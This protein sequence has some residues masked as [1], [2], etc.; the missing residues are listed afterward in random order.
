MNHFNG[1]E[2]DDE[3]F[4]EKCGDVLCAAFMQAEKD[5]D[6]DRN[7]I[8][9]EMDWLE[10]QWRLAESFQQRSE[11][12]SRSSAH[13]V[14]ENWARTALFRTHESQ[15]LSSIV[16]GDCSQFYSKKNLDYWFFHDRKDYYLHIQWLNTLV[17]SI[18]NGNFIVSA[19]TYNTVSDRVYKIS[20]RLWSRIARHALWAESA[21]QHDLSRHQWL[22]SWFTYAFSYQTIYYI[23]EQIEYHEPT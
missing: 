20:S 3:L 5:K 4:L 16:N 1:F 2:I 6:D 8:S 10:K 19:Y 15:V 14:Y 12:T 7:K 18:E 22:G 9:K 23:R 21:N 17:Q 11:V 13:R